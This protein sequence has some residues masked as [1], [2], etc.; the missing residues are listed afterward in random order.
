VQ[1]YLERDVR[2]VTAV[3]DLALFRRFLALVATRNACPLNKTEIATPLGVSVPTVGQ[4]LSV[5]ETTGVVQLVPPYFENLGKRLVK[6]P[7]LY[8]VDTGLL[9]HLLGFQDAESLSRSP[10]VGGVFEAFIASEIV[11]RQHARGRPRELYTFRDQQGLEVDFVVPDGRKVTLVEAKWTRTPVPTMARPL[12]SLLPRFSDREAR[13]LVVYRGSTTGGPDI[14]NAALAPGVAAV[15]V[16]RW[17][18]TSDGKGGWRKEEKEMSEIN[19]KSCL[20]SATQI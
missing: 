1:T 17:L 20:L 19:Q 6:T 7:K 12:L 16:E 3:H 8:F 9:C 15:S 18:G 13:G 11:K 2:A 10:L 14:E 5:L 4:W